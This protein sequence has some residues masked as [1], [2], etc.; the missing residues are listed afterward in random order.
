MWCFGVMEPGCFGTINVN[1]NKSTLFVPRLPQEYEV[2]MGPLLSLEDIKKKYEVDEVYYV[3][4]VCIIQL[5]NS[6]PY[7]TLVNIYL[8]YLQI[9]DVLKKND[10]GVLLTMVKQYYVLINHVI[11]KLISFLER[12]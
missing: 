8:G 3:D 2:W 5:I 11:D 9:K 4:Q 12:C 1:N 10:T 6:V 7:T